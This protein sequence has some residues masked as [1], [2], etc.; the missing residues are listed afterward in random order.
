MQVGELAKQL[1]NSFGG[2]LATTKENPKANC[3]AITTRSG[4]VILDRVEEKE[5]QKEKVE[6]GEK[7]QIVDDD[8]M[9]QNS[10]KT[11]SQLAKEGKL[12]S[13]IFLSKEKPYPHMSMKRDKERH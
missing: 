4:L 8:K 12:I 9:D 6:E 3:C 1:Q 10:T 2:F 7:S 5:K 13:K 11:M